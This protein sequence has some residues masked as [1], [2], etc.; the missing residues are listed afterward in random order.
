[1]IKT[2]TVQRE[3]VDETLGWLKEYVSAENVRW[4]IVNEIYPE[5]DSVTGH[6]SY[7]LRISL[8]V[9]EEE[10]TYLTQFILRFV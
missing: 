1:M 3:K 5:W 4:W 2:F 10:E 9:S 8:D 7:D 6:R